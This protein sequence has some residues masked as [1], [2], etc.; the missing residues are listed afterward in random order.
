MNKRKV[1]KAANKHPNYSPQMKRLTKIK[2]E[3]NSVAC[4]FRHCEF[5]FMFSLRRELACFER[6][7]NKKKWPCAVNE[8]R[9]RHQAIP[10]QSQ[11]T[12]EPSLCHQCFIIG[13]KKKK[14]ELIRFAFWLNAMFA[15]VFFKKIV[16]DRVDSVIHLFYYTCS[17][18]L[19]HIFDG[20]PT[21]SQAHYWWVPSTPRGARDQRCSSKYVH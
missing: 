8:K 7:M 10:K 15:I 16:I 20:S 19:C 21:F 6:R 9:A 2:R 4:L 13:I 14:N 17:L 12:A 5:Y 18:F 11:S 1:S 3:V